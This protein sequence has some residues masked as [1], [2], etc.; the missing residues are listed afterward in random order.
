[1]PDACLCGFD[2]SLIFVEVN[3]PLQEQILGDCEDIVCD[4]AGA[5]TTLVRN[6]DIPVDGNDCTDD[7]CSEGL[8]ANPA[9]ELGT[10]CGA[11]LSCDGL[12][13]CVGCTL[14]SQCG[15]DTFC[16]SFSCSQ[17]ICEI[18]N[19]ANDTVL[20]SDQT[21][22][23][24]QSLV[25]D[26]NGLVAS[27]NDNVDVP[28]EEPNQC[29]SPACAL[30]LPSL[31]YASVGSSC[32]FDFQNATP[33]LQCDG[34]GTCFTCASQADCNYLGVPCQTRGECLSGDSDTPGLCRAVAVLEGS[35]CEGTGE[36]LSLCIQGVCTEF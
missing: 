30:G 26:G 19:T 27:V 24:C 14:E 16:Q 7:L 8:P 25:C 12:G 5:T 10:T 6:S 31:D 2:C 29:T 34:A 22:G 15:T 20:P 35:T 3:T 36:G 32:T 18:S 17:G 33:G 1:M 9:S 4:G 23:D 21:D 28:D 11:D 13:A